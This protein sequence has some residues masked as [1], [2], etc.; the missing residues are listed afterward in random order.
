MVHTIV[1]L[2]L[3][4][5]LS[6]IAGA[7]KVLGGVLGGSKS[8]YVDAL[9]SIANTMSIAFIY[10]FYK[11]SLEP[12]DQDHPFGH[13]RFAFGGPI[14]TLMLYSFVLGVVVTDIINAFG[15]PYVITIQAPIYA[16]IGMAFYALAVTFSKG[17]KT[18]SIY[19]AKFT[20]I[21]FLEGLAT[22]ASSL[23]GI[24]ISFWID[25][26]TATA[27]VLYLAVELWSS[28][29]EITYTI[30]DY[31]QVE[32]ASKISSYLS[33]LGFE[34]KRIRIRRV[35]GDMYQGDATVK[36]QNPSNRDTSSLIKKAEEEIMK[37]FKA[38]VVLK[39]E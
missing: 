39:L 3:S 7:F 8:V 10:A 26:I 1:K 20:A 33:E 12:P 27:L 4:I 31:S 14:A 29:N 15:R 24:F 28:L 22:I 34:V 35:F 6:F 16:A 17:V 30:S 37:K 9:T 18:L 38:D 32:I 36:M 21:E 19:Y 11:K 25:Y 13:L 2:Q 5:T 23:G